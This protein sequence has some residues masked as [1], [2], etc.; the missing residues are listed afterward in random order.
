MKKG[1]TPSDYLEFLDSD[2]GKILYSNLRS[3]VE[4]AK[5][6]KT[7]AILAFVGGVIAAILIRLILK[8]YFGLVLILPGIYFFYIYS[9]ESTIVTE[10]QRKFNDGLN[11]FI[12]GDDYLSQKC[13][14]DF[15]PLG[16]YKRFT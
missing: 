8:T 1:H 14:V 7:K 15:I 5:P 3:S 4:K 13:N 10:A 11:R 2:E 9:N 6:F 12:F 16:F